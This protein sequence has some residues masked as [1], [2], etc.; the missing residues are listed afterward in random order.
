[1]NDSS[2]NCEP[3]M[4]ISTLIKRVLISFRI[5]FCASVCVKFSAGSALCVTAAGLTPADDSGS[6]GTYR[7]E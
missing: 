1:M 6:P 5:L 3:N 4:N 2:L 7:P